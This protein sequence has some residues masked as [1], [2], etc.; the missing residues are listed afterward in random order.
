MFSV[1]SELIRKNRRLESLKCYHSKNSEE[2]TIMKILSSIYL[3][4]RTRTLLWFGFMC[5][6]LTLSVVYQI[7]PGDDVLI[8]KAQA[9]GGSIPCQDF[10]VYLP[11][12]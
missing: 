11:Y 9:C 1:R 3:N 6:L 8:T 10:K 5:L 12:K 2:N 4:N 7:Y